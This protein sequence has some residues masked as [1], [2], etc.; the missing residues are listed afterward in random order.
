MDITVVKEFS[1]DAAHYLPDHPGDC[2]RLHGHTY[3]LQVGIT[4]PVDPGTGMVI[5]FTDL[6]E[7]L[8]KGILAAVDHQYLNEI[9]FSEGL[10]APFPYSNPTA[11]RMVEWIVQCLVVI[12]DREEGFLVRPTFVRL[13]ETPT[14]YAEWRE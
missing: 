10:P 1:F 12:C 11:E 9:K 6:R 5:D 4:G 7:K 8:V 3:T 14:A 13:Y 2:S